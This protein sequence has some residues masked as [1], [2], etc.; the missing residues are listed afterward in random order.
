MTSAPLTDRIAAQLGME[1]RL[2]ARR[3]ENV[4]ATLVIPIALL[5]FFVA[6]PI[7]LPPGSRAVDAVVPA[8]VAVAIISAGLVN[9]GI[10]TGYERAYGVL[11]RLGASPLSRPALVVAKIGAVVVL[12]VVQLA[13]I[14]LVAFG[15]LGWRPGGVDVPTL[16]AALVLGTACF[17]G[18]GLLLA[19]TLR[20]EATLALA[21]ALFLGFVL[22]GGVVVP[23]D[24]LPAALAA[25]ARALPGGALADALRVAL[26]GQADPGL[27]GAA[28]LVV[29]G[30]WTLVTVGGAVRLFRWE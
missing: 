25:L 24:G 22:V 23:P 16:V 28:P 3:G 14:A 10:A 17:A 15:L 26:G 30:I 4:L 18:L 27:P 1:L 29:L 19:G 12:E 2:T 11:K 21:N 9:L 13:L 8:I 20:A 6:Y 7:G 5:V